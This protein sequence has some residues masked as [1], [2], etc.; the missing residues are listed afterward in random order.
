MI[1][2]YINL[3][4]LVKFDSLDSSTKALINNGNLAY[5]WTNSNGNN[6]NKLYSMV[7]TWTNNAIS[8]STYI[9]GG[10]IATNTITAD[11]I[12]ANTITANKIAANTITADKIAANTITCLL[13]TSRC[14]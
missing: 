10:W 2:D 6:M 5:S 14:V 9:Q 13:Y 11:K 4:G 8:D 7:G 12:A 1:S 3:K